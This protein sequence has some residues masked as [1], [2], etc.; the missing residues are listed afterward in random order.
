MDASKINGLKQYSSQE[1]SVGIENK[2]LKLR[3]REKPSEKDEASEEDKSLGG[4]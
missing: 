3:R 2:K 1:F 4:G